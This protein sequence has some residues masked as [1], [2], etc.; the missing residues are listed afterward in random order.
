MNG[1]YGGSKQQIIIIN[2]CCTFTDNLGRSHRAREMH[3]RD[4]L[5]T[6]KQLSGQVVG[7][8]TQRRTWVPHMNYKE[9]TIMYMCKRFTISECTVAYRQG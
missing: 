1:S 2:L 8:S 5:V 6:G 3:T 4:F 7:Y 9:T